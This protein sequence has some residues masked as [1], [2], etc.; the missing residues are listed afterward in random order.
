[1]AYYILNASRQSPE[2]GGNHE[3]HNTETCDT[4]PASLNQL[5]VGYFNDCHSAVSAAKQKYS[6]V[7]HLIDGCA[8]CC[9][10][11]HHG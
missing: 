10:A 3:V 7:S 8:R 6:N 1:M 9:P 11:F 2:L 4:L 5:E